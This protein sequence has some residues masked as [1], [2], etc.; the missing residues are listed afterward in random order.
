MSVFRYLTHPQVKIDAEVPVPDWGLNETGAA[1]AASLAARA[2]DKLSGTRY[3]VT[4]TEQKA[5][6]TAGPI[7]AALGLDLVT[8]AK[9]HE[10]DRSATGFLP[11]PEF[12]AMADRFFAAP[13]VSAEGWERAVDAQ[14]RILAEAES[15]LA[16]APAG[17]ILMVGHGAVGTLLMSHF[18]GW[19]I[20]RVHDQ[21]AGGGNFFIADR[22]TLTLLSAWQPME[23]L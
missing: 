7:G 6:E 10:N 4:S 17:D 18:A 12:E 3:L 9:S 16:D 22:E 2:T 21:P 8:R 11:G 13:E 5:L 23:E 19:P 20:S 14:A 1:R 15:V